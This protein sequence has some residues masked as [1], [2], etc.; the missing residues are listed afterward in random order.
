MKYVSLFVFFAFIL[1]SQL[2]SQE[3]SDTVKKEKHSNFPTDI[4]DQK[5]DSII[6]GSVFIK[7]DDFNKGAIINSPLELIKGRVPGLLI[8]NPGG[9][10]PN[11][12][13]ELQLRGISTLISY[14]KPLII[15]DG[16]QQADI[17]T[18][19]PEDIESIEVLKNVSDCAIYGIE[20]F[21]GVISI[22]TK[23][24][25]TKKP[26]LSYSSY[27]TIE[28]VTKQPDFFSASDLRR[29]KSDYNGN[30][31]VKNEIN[32]VPDYGSNTNWLKEISQDK[33]SQVH[34]LYFNA[35][36]R[37]TSLSFFGNYRDIYGV[38]KNTGLNSQ[39][40]HVNLRHVDLEDRF[41]F[42][43]AY[44]ITDLNEK[45]YFNPSVQH[46]SDEIMELAEKYNPTL[47]VY[48]PDHTYATDSLSFSTANPV[49]VLNQERSFNNKITHLL[50][51]SAS[52]KLLKNLEISFLYAK[53][54]H[55]N[56]KGTTY[57][58]LL[59][60]EPVRI[61]SQD[62]FKVK[63]NFVETK[64]LYSALFSNHQIEVAAGFR[65]QTMNNSYGRA[66]FS[67]QESIHTTD[68][69]ITSIR[70]FDI[71]PKNET[72]YGSLKYNFKGRY[73]LSGCLSS[74]KNNSYEKTYYFK[75]FQA[76]WIISRES[77]M[78]SISWLDELKIRS[79]YGEF[80]KMINVPI[81]I[82]F[83]YM[84][85]SNLHGEKLT[86]WN[87]G[88]DIILFTNKLHVR[89]DCY[90]KLNRGVILPNYN[91][92]FVKPQL[93]NACD[94]SNKGI[95]VSIEADP[96]LNSSFHWNIHFSYSINKNEIQSVLFYPSG[97]KEG[98]PVGSMYG[99]KITGY[100]ENNK[101]LLA[102]DS[103]PDY[104]K[105]GEGLPKSGFSYINALYYKKF[106][107]TISL[108]GVFDSDIWN[109]NRANN[110]DIYML[111]LMNVQKESLDE[112]IIANESVL[113]QTNYFIE[114][115]DY[116]KID[117]VTLGYNLQI[118]KK[119]IENLRLYMACNNVVTFTKFKGFDPEMV[120]ITGMT[121]GIYER[122]T[123]PAT[124][125]YA[126]G[127]KMNFGL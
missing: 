83:S 105:I 119:Y 101:V 80:D 92:M 12:D 117:N 46:N 93:T 122:D 66:M 49:N 24:S 61:Y 112:R 125:L 124:R 14:S 6:N 81:D 50:D 69:S 102:G 32:S 108:R 23:K 67:N 68:P 53:Q 95:E 79:G 15:I 29:L 5:R 43:I 114:K 76:G 42:N 90:S 21:N 58:I 97:G 36:Q 104:L 55:E 38:I 94:I 26:V 20:G 60:N 11:R 89:M 115:G 84:G 48:N 39:N 9:N 75:S 87:F 110:T 74:E 28:Q 34:N 44:R 88:S 19:M 85:N 70:K 22:K 37:K 18:V 10:N 126:F 65:S 57:S 100:D 7:S 64:L 54:D 103:N 41:K 27:G 8:T 96:V 73:F 71:S 91:P 40:V 4:F 13:V 107:L 106:D 127:L 111:G 51:L 52:Y 86:E 59:D 99:L 98:E 31:Q 120:N 33:I 16:V 56:D 17:N 45:Y 116:I 121:P 35:G 2:F 78:Q 123:Y 82:D 30:N 25:Y 1:T 3:T 47:P 62:Y 113:K 109:K 77:F 118:R 63:M 72:K